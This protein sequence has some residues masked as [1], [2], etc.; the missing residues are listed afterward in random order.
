[1]QAR[2]ARRLVVG[3]M[4][5]MVAASPSGA[6]DY[7]PAFDPS[8]LKGAAEGP[9]N[10]VMVL[11]TMHLSGLPD[12]FDRAALAPLIERLARW[13]PAAIATE[14]LS[15]LQCDSLRR[16]PVRYAQTVADYCFDPAQAARATGLDVPAA[17]AEAERIL[18]NWPTAPT[19]AQRRRLAAVFLAAGERGSALVQWL[20]LAPDQ[21]RSSAELH[22]ELVAYLGRYAAR[23]NESGWVAAE[24]AARLGHERLWS[25]DDHS[26]DSP[27]P[28]DPDAAKA[29]GEAITRA[30]DN[31][32]T[33]ARQAADARFA[34]RLNQPGAVLDYYRAIN[35]PANARLVFQSDFGAALNDRSPQRFG[36]NYVAY[37]E[38]RNMRMASNILD[39]LGRAPGTRLLMIVGAAH[40]GHLEAY[41][42]QSHDV[43]VI[44]T[45][46][47]LRK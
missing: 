9:P 26:A 36:R 4:A 13:H 19:A 29:Q 21:R 31:P 6:T 44:D 35:G 46:P 3:T 14:D 47:L 12:S 41:L 2:A 33:K 15:G 1:M 22:A 42:H 45:A 8:R 25:V 27:G 20:R 24:L 32:A 37:W 34:Q 38:T 5:A 11:S 17:N 43:R 30:W 7:R 28:D 39:V 16:Y 10:E 23:R 18:A 40:K